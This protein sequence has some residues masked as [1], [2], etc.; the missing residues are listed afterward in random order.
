[1]K[2]VI[3]S[4]LLSTTIFASIKVNIL[5]PC[6]GKIKYRIELAEYFSNVGS[7]SIE[8][9][10]QLNIDFQGNENSIVSIDGT[11]TGV[12]AY[13]VIS[14][15]EIRAYGW[16]YSVNGQSP[17]LMPN[18]YILQEDQDHQINWH[19]GY[20]LHKDGLWITQ[21]TPAWSSTPNLVCDNER[22]K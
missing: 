10:N 9:L 15:S 13:L 17:E 14:D 5:D 11:P 18:E 7:A 3:L 1:M 8:A 6:S 22:L 16:C 19:F 21:C 12:D 20:A 4:L 2:K